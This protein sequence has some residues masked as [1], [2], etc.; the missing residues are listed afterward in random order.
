MQIFLALIPLLAYI[1]ILIYLKNRYPSDPTRRVLIHSTIWFSC[2]LVLCLELL[3]IFRW[4][5][6]LGLVIVWIVPILVFA[7]WLW[8]KKTAGERVAVPEFQFPSNWWNRFLLL[9]ICVVL[10]ITALV[11]WV[12]PPQTWDS[13]TYHLSRVA[14]WAQDRSIW[15]YATGIDRQ[16]SMPPG[17]EELILNSYVLTQSDRL[18]SFPQWFSML[19]SLIG[20]SLIAYYLGA[21][22]SGQWLAAGFA[23]TIPMG[24][25]ESSSTINDYVA[26]F[27]VVC[28]VVECLA[29][30][31]Q[32]ETRSLIYISLAAGLAMLTKPVAVPFLIPFALWLAYL[33]V[34][35]HGFLTLLKW[36]G[37]AILVIGLINVGY[38]T[39][40]YITYGALSNPVDFETHYNQL[41]SIPGFIATL[42]KNIG[43]QVGLPYLDGLNHAWYLLILKIV[44]KLGLDINDPRMTAVGYFHIIAPSTS[45]DVASNPYHAYL[46]F[47]LFIIMFFMIKKLGRPL[48]AYGLLVA[49][50]FLLFSFIYKWNAFG[51][52]YDLAFFVL[53]APAAG[54]ILEGFNKYKPGYLVT[55]LLLIGAFPWLFSINSRPLITPPE[56]TSNQKSI[57]VDSRQDL[58]FT[59]APS[60]RDIYTRFTDTIKNE[61]CSDIGLMLKG[62]DPEYLLWVLTGAPRNHVRI[63]WIISGP[64]DRYSPPDFKPCAI[65]CRGCTIEQSPVRGLTIAQQ[66]GDTWLYLPPGK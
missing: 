26:T 19:G 30:Y 58:Y 62:D 2:Y 1:C 45:E 53:F 17:A 44:V 20:V 16:T 21:K 27:W 15:H 54:I 42:L 43:M 12:T 33:L 31:K 47:A 25:V 23:A 28:V 9:I 14:H 48:I 60:V 63:E 36:G 4:I 49:S 56:S 55:T 50:T 24:I 32:G 59:N 7:F 57:L 37:V 13:L 35:R 46:I 6:V 29:Y 39:R 10:I 5:T 8:Y 52:R 51:T 41:H 18:A 66:L 61:G 22:S 34:K 64:T 65:I 3:S 11:A 38:L 40:N